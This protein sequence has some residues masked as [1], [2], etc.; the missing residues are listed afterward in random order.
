MCFPWW[1]WQELLKC[2][3]R[4]KFNGN[5][6]GWFKKREV[7]NVGNASALAFTTNSTK[8]MCS[9]MYCKIN[10]CWK[11]LENGG[12]AEGGTFRTVRNLNSFVFFLDDLIDYSF[13]KINDAFN[14]LSKIL[15]V[16]VGDWN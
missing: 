16:K 11:L 8:L 7:A 2:V 14:P 1:E 9:E 10:Y 13:L 3:A 15:V 12:V 5:S 4:A 6:H